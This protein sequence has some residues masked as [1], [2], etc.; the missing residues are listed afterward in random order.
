MAQGVQGTHQHRQAPT[1]LCYVTK[2]GSNV[3]LVH[4]LPLICYVK[5]K[6]PSSQNVTICHCFAFKPTSYVR[7][8]ANRCFISMHG[9]YANRGVKHILVLDMSFS[10]VLV[11]VHV[12][13]SIKEKDVTHRIV[14]K[15]LDTVNLRAQQQVGCIACLCSRYVVL[16]ACIWYKVHF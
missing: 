13:C 8:E 3:D 6:S 5:S 7:H 10:C 1:L 16:H 11:F 9:V 12:A 4:L 15:D 2:S 14:K